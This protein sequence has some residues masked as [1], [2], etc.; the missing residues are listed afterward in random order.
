M[1]HFLQRSEDQ[2]RTQLSEMMKYLEEGFKP[3]SSHKAV[4]YTV[5]HRT[6]H[7]DGPEVVEVKTSDEA[8]PSFIRGCW[9]CEPK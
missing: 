1:G 6:T 5:L 3:I 8:T 2:H 7:V 9:N 4:L